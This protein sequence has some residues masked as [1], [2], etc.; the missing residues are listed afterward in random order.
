MVAMLDHELAIKPDDLETKVARAFVDLDWKA[1][2]RPLHQIIDQTRTKDPAGLRR[3]ANSW[4]ACA[5]AERDA[6][7]AEKA[8][9][10]LGD[11]HLENEAVILSQPLLQGVIARMTKDDAK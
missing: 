7:A 5:L 8:V 4:F 6:A 2:T 3:I 9:T 11:T 10:A 1:D